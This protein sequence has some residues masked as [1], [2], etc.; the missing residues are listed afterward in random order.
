MPPATKQ[1]KTARLSNAEKSSFFARREAAKVLTSVLD[2]DARR[3]AVGSIKTLVFKPSV[4]NK[5][6]TFALVCET[7]KCKLIINSLYFSF[8]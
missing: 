7:L 1:K 8:F 4:R 5:K 2:G 6:A 3:Q